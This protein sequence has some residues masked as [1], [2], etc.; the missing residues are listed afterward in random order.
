MITFITGWPQTFTVFAWCL[1]LVTTLMVEVRHRLRPIGPWSPALPGP[2]RDTRFWLLLFAVATHIVVV[3]EGGLL[4]GGARLALVL[5][6]LLWT[7]F[8]ARAIWI[9]HSRRK[10]DGPAFKLLVATLSLSLLMLA[11][12]FWKI[13]NVPPMKAQV[14]LPNADGSFTQLMNSPSM[15]LRSYTVSGATTE[16]I[17]ASL[18]AK[19]PLVNGS[20]H[21]AFTQWY[22]TWR[23]PE[24]DDHG[25]CD[26]SKLEVTYS[27]VTSLPELTRDRPV[28]M[29][30][31]ERWNAYAEALR[32]RENRHLQQ[33]QPYMDEIAEAIRSAGC[34]KG[35]DAG[36]AAWAKINEQE[37]LFYAKD[38]NSFP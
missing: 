4:H 32:V 12:F 22:F 10:Q 21:D 20:H 15:V 14:W 5:W 6:W 2:D 28:P 9:H 33:A 30:L 38:G 31:Q 25:G 27:A 24:T 16:E 8:V 36:L 11:G 23:W 17:R 34:A 35:H 26:L 1:T 37:R 19:S 13:E 3:V 18:D 29:D 7:S